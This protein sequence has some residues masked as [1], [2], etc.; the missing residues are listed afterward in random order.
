MLDMSNTLTTTALRELQKRHLAEVL[1]MDLA[2]LQ[3]AIS[4]GEVS[5]VEA[6]EWIVSRV[7][8]YESHT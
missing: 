7:S 3:A 4:R 6:Q 2:T 5:E 8:G 1:G